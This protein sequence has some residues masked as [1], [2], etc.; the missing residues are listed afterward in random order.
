MSYF[1]KIAKN[2]SWTRI[3]QNTK[4]I[5]ELDHIYSIFCVW[6]NSGTTFISN[7]ALS[8]VTFVQGLFM[9]NSLPM[10]V[11]G[12]MGN[13]YDFSCGMKCCLI[14]DGYGRWANETWKPFLKGNLRTIYMCMHLKVLPCVCCSLCSYRV[15]T[16]W[17]KVLVLQHDWYIG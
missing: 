13:Q 5:R 10:D 12:K 1:G 9:F 6:T 17:A 7:H 3:S 15:C 11:L 2:E 8:S 14:W 4:P 16:V